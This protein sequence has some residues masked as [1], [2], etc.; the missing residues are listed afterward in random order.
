MAKRM[1]VID[2]LRRRFPGTW[3]YNAKAN[4]Y[5]HA[6][7]W[8]VS[9]YAVQC[10]Y[11]EDDYTTGWMRSDTGTWVHG[12]GNPLRVLGEGGGR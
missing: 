3:R 10:G 1:R 2:Q 9:P 7:G 8:H 4:R 12:L 5:E 6:D 11:V